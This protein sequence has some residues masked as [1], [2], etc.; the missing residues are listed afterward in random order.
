[1]SGVT[2]SEQ[3]AVNAKVL[4]FIQTSP[5]P[6][7]TREMKTALGIDQHSLDLALKW[8][9]RTKQAEFWSSVFRKEGKGGWAPTRRRL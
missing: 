8:A 9:T 6:V 5:N 1:M 4:E 2:S 7:T 3:M